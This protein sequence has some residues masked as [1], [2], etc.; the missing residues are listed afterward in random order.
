MPASAI[1][2]ALGSVGAFK[3]FAITVGVLL[4]LCVF[5]DYVAI[6]FYSFFV[7]TAVL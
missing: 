1:F 2:F 4:K 3:T 7:N 5:A 6:S